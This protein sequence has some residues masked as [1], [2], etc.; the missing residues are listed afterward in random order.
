MVYI[1]LKVT[2]AL[3]GVYEKT[4]RM[5]RMPDDM[6]WQ[7]LTYL[8]GLWIGSAYEWCGRFGDG[9]GKFWCVDGRFLTAQK[10]VGLNKL[11]EDG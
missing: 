6:Q 5:G 4:T 11:P 2:A 9:D 10:A 3:L 1:G 7:Q 8:N